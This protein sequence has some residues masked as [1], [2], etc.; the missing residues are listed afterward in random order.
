M[1]SE[2]LK[3][4]ISKLICGKKEGVPHAVLYSIL[5]SPLE[6]A[7]AVNELSKEGFLIRVGVGKT[8]IYYDSKV[9]DSLEA[10]PAKQVMRPYVPQTKVELPKSKPREK[11]AADVEAEAEQVEPE[12]SVPVRVENVRRWPIVQKGTARAQIVWVYMSVGIGIT[13]GVLLKRLE[14]EWEKSQT[15]PSLARNTLFVY[16]HILMKEGFIE[17]LR[18]GTYQYCGPENPFDNSDIPIF[19]S[20]EIPEKKVVFREVLVREQ[21]QHVLQLLDQVSSMAETLVLMQTKLARMSEQ[22]KAMA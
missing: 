6:I 22:L 15:K 19:G 21:S 11:K 12:S 8:S 3:D 18:R 2:E 14:E 20:M 16:C 5:V 4:E 17:R 10:T 13:N 7:K 1:A 9:F